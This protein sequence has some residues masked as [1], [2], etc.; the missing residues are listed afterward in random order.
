MV[1]LVFSAAPTTAGTPEEQIQKITISFSFNVSYDAI[2]TNASVKEAFKA[3]VKSQLVSTLGVKEER[4]TNLTITKGSI[5]VT[6]DLLP[7]SNSS[8]PTLTSS[9]SKLENLVKSGG[10]V[11]SFN[12]QNITA[13]T[14]SSTKQVITT[15][16]TTA[17]PTKG[18]DY[19]NKLS[20]NR[21]IK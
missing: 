18:K 20:T 11:V 4:I 3:N 2:I 8:E 10:M 16:P 14:S 21:V 1:K 5:V 6:F 17:P 15:N 7:S 12:G 19:T 13:D 9:A